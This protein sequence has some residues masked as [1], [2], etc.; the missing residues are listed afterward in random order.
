GPQGATPMPAAVLTS[1]TGFGLSGTVGDLAPGASSALVV[2]AANP[3][4]VPITLTSLTVS[5]PAVPANCP[6]SDLTLAST[7]FTGSPPTVTVTGLSET[8]PA[9]GSASVSLGVLLRT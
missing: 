5:V 3:Y 4:G 1:A 7:A 6:V 2:T 8:V 9:N